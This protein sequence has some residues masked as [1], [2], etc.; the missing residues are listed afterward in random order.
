[1]GFPNDSVAKNLFAIAEDAGD[2]GS[3]PGLG[4]STGGE[5][6]THSRGKLPW[7]TPGTEEPGRLQYMGSQ[8]VVYTVCTHTGHT[9]HRIYRKVI[10]RVNPESSHHKENFSLCFFLFF[11]FESIRE[12]RCEWNPLWSSFHSICE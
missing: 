9:L 11:F 3:T 2:M 7:K 12:D 1:M 10:T 8:T 6:A 4:R 5:M